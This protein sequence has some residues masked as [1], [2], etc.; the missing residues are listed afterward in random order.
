MST[1]ADRRLVIPLVLLCFVVFV[2]CAAAEPQTIKGRAQE[3]FAN[4]DMMDENAVT[5]WRELIDLGEEAYPAVLEILDETDD[6][7]I[8]SRALAFFIESS[9]D[10]RPAIE[11]IGRVL[12]RT[13]GQGRDAI[14]LRVNA[15][16]ALGK[17]GGE[18]DCALLYPLLYDKSERVRINVMRTLAG[19]GNRETVERIEA[20]LAERTDGW[21][22]EEIRKDYSV[23]EGRK[24][25]EAIQAR[26]SQTGSP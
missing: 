12:E 13:E 17:I 25:V 19:L 23:G 20:S 21:A 16:M 14:S 9:G 1:R 15:V 8:A 7:M 5:A 18:E 24:A 26:L 11:A 22:E 4:D 6:P 10:K 3:I 2:Q